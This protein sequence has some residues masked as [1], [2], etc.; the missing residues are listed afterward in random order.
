MIV[1]LLKM[2]YYI[3][4]TI[5]TIKLNITTHMYMTECSMHIC[6]DCAMLLPKSKYCRYRII[7]NNIK[8]KLKKLDVKYFLY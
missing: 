5:L 2:G 8:L 6:R 7:I 1:M 4:K 3:N